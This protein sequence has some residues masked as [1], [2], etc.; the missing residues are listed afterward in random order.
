MLLKPE[1]KNSLPP[2]TYSEY[3]NLPAG[4]TKFQFLEA[5]KRLHKLS[6]HSSYGVQVEVERVYVEDVIFV[7]L[8]VGSQ[9]EFAH[10]LLKSNKTRL[11]MGELMLKTPMESSFFQHLI[12]KN[13]WTE[14]LDITEKQRASFLLD[15]YLG[16]RNINLENEPSKAFKKF[17]A[18]VIALKEMANILIMKANE[19]SNQGVLQNRD[20]FNTSCND[21]I[22]L[23]NTTIAAVIDLLKKFHSN[24]SRPLQNVLGRYESTSV[25]RD[26]RRKNSSVYRAF[27]REL[28]P[29]EK[30]RYKSH[31][32]KVGSL[33]SYV[34]WNYKN[35]ASHSKR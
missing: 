31:V 29:K 17:A 19:Y 9:I 7:F 2:T 10:K 21:L 22:E 1:D 11:E 34:V 4:S 23:K 5:I 3:R 24:K 13:E 28:S 27:C 20:L 33:D 35:V 6:K 8:E 32:S 12:P 18:L 30:K 16:L 25:Y 14:C 15:E 26:I